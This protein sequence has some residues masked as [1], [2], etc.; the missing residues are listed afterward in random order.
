[1]WLYAWDRLRAVRVDYAEQHFGLLGE[2]CSATCVEA[3]ER[4]ARFHVTTHHELIGFESS[5]NGSNGSVSGSG[6][7]GGVGASGWAGGVATGKAFATYLKHSADAV[8]S[9]LA[10]LWELYRHVLRERIRER[11]RMPLSSTRNLLT[12]PSYSYTAVWKVSM[13]ICAN[14]TSMLAPV[15][16]VRLVWP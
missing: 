7:V 5:G 12:L 14:T 3:F 9:T 13:T 6:G 2:R 16:P 1:M 11:R 10:T 4:I 15:R 8:T